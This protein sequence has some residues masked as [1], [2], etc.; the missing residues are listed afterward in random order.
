[1][2]VASGSEILQKGTGYL[3]DIGWGPGKMIETDFLPNGDPSFKMMTMP[4]IPLASWQEESLLK[5]YGNE[6]T[7]LNMPAIGGASS[8]KRSATELRQ[9]NSAAGTR[10]ALINTRFRVACT[11]VINFQHALNKQ[12]LQK[13]PTTMV[14][15]EVFT[16][17]LEVLDQDY[18]IGVAGSSDPIDSITRKNDLLSLVD[19]L[20]TKFPEDFQDPV[21]RFYL[22]RR[23][24]EAWGFGN[25]IPQIIGTEQDAMQAKQAMQ[26][27]QQA[28]QQADMQ[29]RS[30]GLHP[31][32]Q[33]RGKPP[34]GGKAP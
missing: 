31:E 7:G 5:S 30:Q 21:K 14:N 19:V 3:S 26:Q 27:Q 13:P 16:L 17:P 28:A 6:Y 4:D 22:K 11:Q 10:L 32:Q 23:I 1:M 15:N 29:A 18:T 25:D 8:G 12:Y 24:L 2:A 9:Q 33:Q 20:M 34:A